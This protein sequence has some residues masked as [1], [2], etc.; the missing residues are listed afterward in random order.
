MGMGLT[1]AGTCQN[2]LFAGK[3][4]CFCRIVFGYI[5]ALIPDVVRHIP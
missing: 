5:T 2:C 1:P 4:G 3:F